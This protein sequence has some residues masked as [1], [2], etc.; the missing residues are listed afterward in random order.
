[1]FDSKA[2]PDRSP[3][4]GLVRVV[5]TAVLVADAKPDVLAALFDPRIRRPRWTPGFLPRIP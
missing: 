5:M 1:L 2:K 4:I 3:L